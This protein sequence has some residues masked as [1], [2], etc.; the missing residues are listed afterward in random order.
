MCRI[1][2]GAMTVCM[3]RVLNLN[4]LNSRYLFSK[5]FGISEELLLKKVDNG[6]GKFM[7]DRGCARLDSKDPNFMNDEGKLVRL[8]N[9]FLKHW[10]HPLHIDH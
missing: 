4:A 7:K 5:E 3:Q 8:C 6:D 2:S 1:T 9:D 10:H